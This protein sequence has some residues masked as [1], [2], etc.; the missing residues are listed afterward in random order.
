MVPLGECPEEVIIN[1]ER[2]ALDRW[3]T[4]DTFGFVD[5]ASD[6]ITYFDPY[7]ESRVTGLKDFRDFYASFRFTFSF[8]RY[9]LVNPHVQLYRDT[10]ILTFNFIGYFE[11]GQ[12]NKWNTTEVYHLV[13]GQ[14]KL[15]HSNWSHTKP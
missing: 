8:P 6:D 3:K 5:I 7:V 4:G 13:N 11:N 2:G 9:E 10:A 15:A 14:W 1:I 12:E